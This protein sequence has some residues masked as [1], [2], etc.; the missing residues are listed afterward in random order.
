M[1]QAIVVGLTLLASAA[2]LGADRPIP[3]DAARMEKRS[4][5]RLEW[6][7]RTLQGEYDRVGKKDARWDKPAREAL[8]L[9]A[10][11][12][13]E[14]LDPPV[15]SVDVHAPAQRAIDAGCDDALI[16]YLHI[17]TS[18]STD[19]PNMW[20][21][22]QKLQAVA[23][24]MAGSTY[25]PFRRAVALRVATDIRVRRPKLNQEG[26]P[27]LEKKLDAIL[28]LLGKSVAEDPRGDDWDDG[29]F[30]EIN[31]VIAAHRK[32][33]DDF[34]T[35]FDRVDA[36]LA[37]VQ[38]IEPL[39]LTV[40]G[41]FLIHWGWE[42]RTAQVAVN[43]T[44]EQFRIFEDRLGQARETLKKAWDLHP[45]QPHVADLMLI[46]EKGIGHGDRESMETWFERAMTTNA[47]DYQ[48]CLQK[49]DWLDPKWYGGDSFDPM[50][51]FGR[52]CAA[53]RN[54][55][56]GITLLVADAH[57][58]RWARLPQ[59][60][61]RVAY[62]RTPEVW[63]EIRTAYEEYFK[64]YPDDDLQ[65]SKYAMI[66]YFG[67]HYPAAH[68]QFQA[69]GDRLTTWQGPPNLQLQRL[70]KAREHTATIMARQAGGPG[71]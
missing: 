51:A 71:A 7:R 13:S 43:V 46:V 55:H 18:G 12:F 50:I 2:A 3:Q 15:R 39:R 62:M 14:Q 52:A 27:G 19:F 37:K 25:S 9:A 42:T 53:T 17:R 26:R 44:E 20:D 21:Y 6:N 28:D 29:W 24:A 58:R 65:R 1:R 61:E 59:G 22:D 66:C 56:N 23:E 33:G 38:G 67:A 69:L 34:K 49:L 40:K 16:R 63:N 35:A 5:E 68:A 47:N 4:R 64:H 36:R 57:F 10:R 8:D 41:R 60:P 48:A 32:L 31:A 54:W 30:G 45:G 11:M 70:I